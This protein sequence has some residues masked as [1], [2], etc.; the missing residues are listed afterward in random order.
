MFFLEVNVDSFIGVCCRLYKY[1][2][3]F[4]VFSLKNMFKWIR[5]LIRMDKEK[6]FKVYDLR[7]IF[8]FYEFFKFFN[9]VWGGGG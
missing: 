2:R 3:Y 5:I 6:K 9:S 1:E 4:V 7:G 8:I